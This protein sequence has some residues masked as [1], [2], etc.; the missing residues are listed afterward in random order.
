MNHRKELLE[1][2]WDRLVFWV[3]LIVIAK[4]DMS[5]ESFWKFSEHQI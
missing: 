4:Y 5:I 2:V 3:V 1:L